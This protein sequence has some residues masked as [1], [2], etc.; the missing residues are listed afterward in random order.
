MVDPLAHLTIERL[1]DTL[2]ELYRRTYD[3]WCVPERRCAGSRRKYQLEKYVF[4]T[5]KAAV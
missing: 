1:N 5:G 2:T 4:G 3:M